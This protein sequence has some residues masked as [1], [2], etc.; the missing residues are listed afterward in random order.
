[1]D[2]FSN[3]LPDNKPIDYNLFVL[4]PLSTII[5]LAI[6]SNKA[7]GTKIYIDRNIILFQDPGFFQ[8]ISRY[9]LKTN[10]T[11]LQYL[12]NP[13]ELACKQYLTKTSIQQNPKLKDLF[14]CAQKGLSNLSE[15]YKSCS[16]I[17]ISLNYYSALISNYLDE[18]N[19]ETLFKK[20]NMSI[21]YTSQLLEKMA[22]I[23]TQ[24][25]IKII[26]N[27][28]TFLTNDEH[29]QSDVKSLETLM[30]NIDKTVQQSI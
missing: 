22:K 5:K 24:E 4:D 27:L 21:L 30:N 18:N 28:T 17:R 8:A 3:Y 6:L 26:L 25:K 11:D 10:K 12:Y 20:D 29:A 19:N 14:K 13:I 7:I 23:W 1:M 15:T 9:I 16:M 2:F